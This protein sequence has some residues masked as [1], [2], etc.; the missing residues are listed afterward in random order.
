MRIAASELSLEASSTSTR[1][2]QITDTASFWRTPTTPAGPAPDVVRVSDDARAAALR[3][4]NKPADDAASDPLAGDQ[5][6]QLLRDIVE[7]MTHR[8][9]KQLKPSDLQ[10]PADGPSIPQ[11]R[12]GAPVN[13][14]AAPSRPRVGWGFEETVTHT[15]T[16]HEA[17]SVVAKASVTTSDGNTFDVSATLVLQSDRVDVQ[18]VHVTA[19]D[20]KTR[21]PLVLDLG[22][23]QGTLTAGSFAFDLN[24]DG[25]KLQVQNPGAGSAFLVDD[26]NGNGT[27]DGGSE[28]F[29]ARS[30][31]GF[32]DLKALDGDRNGWIDENDAAWQRLRVW[33]PDTKGNGA[34]RTLADAGVGAIAVGSVASP[35]DLRDGAGAVQGRVASTGVFLT[36]QGVARTVREL[37]LA[38]S[39][40]APPPSAT[41]KGA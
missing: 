23:V 8:H 2:D 6:M 11:T 25:S 18:T 19:G 40:A 16:T 35:F 9:M 7:R 17:S 36:E 29:G 39:D 37:D 4:A 33:S 24:G 3:D 1:T 32:A 15:V 21:D 30:G 26:R 41:E 28:L 13:E 5:R 10:R 22:T 31:N 38:V 12:P 20:P 34:L 27:V 14:R